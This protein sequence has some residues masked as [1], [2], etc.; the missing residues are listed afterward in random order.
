MTCLDALLVHRQVSKAAR[1]LD[2]DQPA[3][4]RLIDRL[5]E[6]GLVERGKGVDRRCVKLTV[7]EAATPELEVMRA[8]MAWLDTELKSHLTGEE[9]VVLERLL[10]KLERGIAE[11]ME[12]RGRLG[13]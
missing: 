8:G 10:V 12:Q 11:P 13:G 2:M 6:D 5:E 4:S 3:M 1:A 7:P 9:Q